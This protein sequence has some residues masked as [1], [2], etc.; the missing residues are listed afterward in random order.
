MRDLPFF[1][2]EYG[3]ASL[4]LQEIPYRADAYIRLQ[5]A[6][7]PPKL[8]DECISFCRAAGANRVFAASDEYPLDYPLHA[9]ILRMSCVRTALA[10]TDASLF[11]LQ[12]ETLPQWVSIYNEKIATVDHAA[13][14]TK[15]KGKQLLL[16]GGGY[17][18]HRNGELLGI[19]SVSRD[20]IT[21]V[22]AVQK[23]SGADVLLALNHA[24]FGET[25]HVEVASTNTAAINLYTR[26]GFIAN[27]VVSE[28]YKV[29]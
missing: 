17:F 2:T 4:T 20:E 13:Y 16:N 29:F 12:E 14:F 9:K 11:P 19:G 18:V 1:T 23:G 25:V 5:K 8:L 22:I 24:L 3:V 26:L 15:E 27:H 10:E 7:D 6:A 28:W 21:T